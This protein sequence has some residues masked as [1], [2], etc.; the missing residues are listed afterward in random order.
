MLQALPIFSSTTVLS[1]CFNSPICTVSFSCLAF[2]DFPIFSPKYNNFSPPAGSQ[3]NF[4]KVKIKLSSDG[5]LLYYAVVSY[6]GNSGL[7]SEVDWLKDRLK[8]ISFPKHPDNK[9]TVLEFILTA[10]E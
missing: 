4:A 8:R 1:S 2:C 6:S 5:R 7:N 3:G 10:K 9:D